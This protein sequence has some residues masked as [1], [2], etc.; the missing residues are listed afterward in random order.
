[1]CESSCMTGM[2]AER[3]DHLATAP[4]HTV[5]PLLQKRLQDRKHNFIKTFRCEFCSFK[6]SVTSYARSSGHPHLWVQLKAFLLRQLHKRLTH[7]Q[8][9]I[10]VQI[11]MHS[12]LCCSRFK[13][14]KAASF[15]KWKK[16]YFRLGT[17]LCYTAAFKNV[18]WSLL[19][20]QRHPEYL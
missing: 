16:Q 4:S 8:L 20:N 7:V 17:G 6:C 14:L 11:Y 3:L 15:F 19:I 1:M 12:F 5:F 9:F 2:A 13:I 18:R 10:S